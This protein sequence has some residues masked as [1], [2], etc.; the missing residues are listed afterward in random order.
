MTIPSSTSSVSGLPSASPPATLPSYAT[1]RAAQPMLA[2]TTK[3]FYWNNIENWANGVLPGEAGAVAD[4]D[5]LRGSPGIMVDDFT[6]LTINTLA[7]SPGAPT[8]E[9]AVQSR[10]VIDQA[11]TNG[12][13]ELDAGARLLEPNSGDSY[14]KLSAASLVEYGAV[15]RG[16]VQF[17]SVPGTTSSLYIST[18]ALATASSP[19][20]DPQSIT[21]FSVGD[22]IYIE[23]SQTGPL[24]ATYTP[25][26]SGAG[27]LWISN[28]ATP[29][30][31]FS[32]FSG[33]AALNYQ[34]TETSV[35]D[36]LTGKAGV[37]AGLFNALGSL[38]LS[39]IRNT[40][41]AK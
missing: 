23:E 28:G 24:S 15:P 19:G 4:I 25:G 6:S 3:V 2:G 18:P 5:I 33:N 12:V 11:V 8:L 7:F 13:I 10:L 30:Y 31:R 1:F 39:P 35:V 9:I 34:V 22:N 41:E 14:V 32:N 26:A 36:P 16:Y 29:V 17:S 37:P 40:C 21:N 20:S 27:T 38:L